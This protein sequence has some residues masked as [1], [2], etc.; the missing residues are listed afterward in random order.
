M[1]SFRIHPTVYYWLKDF[2]E[3]SV[4]PARRSLLPK[5]PAETAIKRLSTV[6][7]TCVDCE[8]CLIDWG[9]R[10]CDDVDLLDGVAVYDVR[11]SRPSALV[12]RVLELTKHGKA[13]LVVK[14][15]L[16]LGGSA[17]MKSARS[18]PVIN[19]MSSIIINP[20]TTSWSA[21]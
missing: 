12:N 9:G 2:M 15:A 14:H 16:P 6:Q 21:V 1:S 3:A 17:S 5:S 4:H 20:P 13:P 8:Q 11:L 19:W 7:N 18:R 10:R